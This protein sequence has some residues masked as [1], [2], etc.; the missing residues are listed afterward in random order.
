V[1]AHLSLYACECVE[2]MVCFTS[3]FAG[4]SLDELSDLKVVLSIS[5]VPRMELP[6]TTTIVYHLT[7]TLF[8]ETK[9][10]HKQPS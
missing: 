5:F 4:A 10:S 9:Y 3:G 7:I 1:Q 2:E 6:N 8:T